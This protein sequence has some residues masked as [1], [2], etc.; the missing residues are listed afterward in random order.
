MYFLCLHYIL[1]SKHNPLTFLITADRSAAELIFLNDDIRE[2]VLL[3]Q[4][5]S[6]ESL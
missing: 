2:Q 5:D 1:L 6:V 4:I 3:D